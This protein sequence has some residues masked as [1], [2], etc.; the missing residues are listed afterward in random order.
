MECKRNCK[1]EIAEAKDT[2][3]EKIYKHHLKFILDVLTL[4]N[5]KEKEEEEY[6]NGFNFVDRKGV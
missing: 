6:P 5:G 4:R 2:R 3:T 1:R